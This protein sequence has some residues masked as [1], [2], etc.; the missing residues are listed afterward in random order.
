MNKIALL[1]LALAALPLADSLAQTPPERPQATPAQMQ[2]LMDAT[3]GAMVPAMGRMMEIMIDTQLAVAER[4]ETATRLA[5]FK[6]NLFDAL[7]KR[8]FSSSQAFQ[9]VLS[10]GIPTASPSA[11]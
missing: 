5:A 6:K 10:T 7:V 11:R 4:P 3:M 9:I 1:A 8:G 2:Q